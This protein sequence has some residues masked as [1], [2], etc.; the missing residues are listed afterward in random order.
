MELRPSL[1]IGDDLIGYG[2]TR[3]RTVTWPLRLQVDGHPLSWLAKLAG[4]EGDSCTV[5]GIEATDVAVRAHENPVSTIRLT[6]QD[7]RRRTQFTPMCFVYKQHQPA[8]K[9]ATPG[10]TACINFIRVVNFTKFLACAPP[11]NSFVGANR[12]IIG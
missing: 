10:K 8:G 9:V 6:T 3:S 11:A 1:G 7:G 4:M 5:T 12:L 2:E